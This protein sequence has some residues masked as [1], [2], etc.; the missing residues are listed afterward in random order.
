MENSLP[1]LPWHKL[2]VNICDYGLDNGKISRKI[3]CVTNH[4]RAKL[5]ERERR[6]VCSQVYKSTF[7]PQ[8][9]SLGDCVCV[10]VFNMFTF[11]SVLQVYFRFLSLS[12]SRQ[13]DLLEWKL[14]YPSNLNGI[15]NTHPN[16]IITE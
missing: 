4:K 14:N 7:H 11:N 8:F 2:R 16:P 13:C 9:L 12:H 5:W 6:N 3:F 15:M 1:M 10:S